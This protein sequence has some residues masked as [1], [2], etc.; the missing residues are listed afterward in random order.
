M[1][2]TDA[3]LGEHGAIY[4]LFDWVELEL[5]HLETLTDVRRI[6]GVVAAV[7]VSHARIENEMLFPALET[8]LGTAGP[9]AVMRQ[10][11]DEID[12][13]L[14]E[15]VSAETP[16]V[17]RERVEHAL[18]VARDHFAKEEQVLFGMAQQALSEQ[19]LARLGLRWA[20]ARRVA[21][22]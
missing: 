1:K 14:R 6:A 20:N 19:E 10:E 17:A 7:L 9:L 12:D 21:V 18:Q 22:G 16:D 5:P 13:A 3:L 4:A 2:L 11:H 15:A 8:H